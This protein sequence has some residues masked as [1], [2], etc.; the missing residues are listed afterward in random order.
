MV[1]IQFPPGTSGHNAGGGIFPEII[2]APP[3]QNAAPT[4]RVNVG[5]T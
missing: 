5:V 3:K 1:I 2:P 4:Q